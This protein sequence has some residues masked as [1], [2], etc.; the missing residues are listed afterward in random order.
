MDT[1]EEKVLVL[2]QRRSGKG[3][4]LDELNKS[5]DALVKDILGVD[6]ATIQYVNRP[7]FFPGKADLEHEF[8]DNE[9][10]KQ[11]ATD[12]SLIICNTCPLPY[13]NYNIINRHL[14]MGGFL[15]LTVYQNY[16]LAAKEIQD[17]ITK[18]GVLPQILKAG[19]NYYE[20]NFKKDALVF[21]KEYSGG[22]RTTKRKNGRSK[23]KHFRK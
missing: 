3:D 22:K 12:Y 21:R 1:Q 10:T 7:G 23:T 15:A 2:C 6:N 13:M 11:L 18:K 17:N 4:E 8:G 19:F 14:R 9:E 5:I 20:I 16:N